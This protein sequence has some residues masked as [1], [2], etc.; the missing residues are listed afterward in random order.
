MERLTAGTMLRPGWELR[1]MARAFVRR[2]GLFWPVLLAC[3]ALAAAGLALGRSQT[4]RAA[5]LAA[6]PAAV[7]PAPVPDEDKSGQAG[8]RS[9]L[10]AFE[11]HLLPHDDIPY[12]VQD[13]LELG[14][15]EGLTMQR[16]SYRPQP[17]AAGQFLRYRMSPPVQGS[18]Q[19]VQRFMNNALRKQNNLALDGVQFKRARIGSADVEARI[20]WVLLATLPGAAP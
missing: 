8:A 6:S 17:D 3:L 4:A 11:A 9:R 13:L 10:R 12:A 5:V 16:G 19:A 14:A 20:D 1:R 15:A 7:R 2:A 18:A